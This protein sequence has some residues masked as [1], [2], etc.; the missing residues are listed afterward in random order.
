[1]C[2]PAPSLIPDYNISQWYL[3]ECHECPL[4]QRLVRTERIWEGIFKEARD[5]RVFET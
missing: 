5:V 2:K 3:L 1:M 4:L